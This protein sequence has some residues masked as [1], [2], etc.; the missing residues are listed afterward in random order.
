MGFGRQAACRASL[1]FN[2]SEQRLAEALDWLLS[3]PAADACGDDLPAPSSH[4]APGSRSESGAAERAARSCSE[5]LDAGSAL[6]ALKR[7]SRHP[8]AK[9]RQHSQPPQ[10]PW[11]ALMLSDDDG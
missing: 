8:G 4:A 11:A 3:A 1:R 5:E 10:N 2:G 6:S 7:P 9:S